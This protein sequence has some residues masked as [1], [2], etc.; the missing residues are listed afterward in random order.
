MRIVSECDSG[1][2]EV[3]ETDGAFGSK[4]NGT[5]TLTEFPA[6]S[7][8]STRTEWSPAVIASSASPSAVRKRI[9]V[10]L[11]NVKITLAT[12]EAASCA[13]QRKTSLFV[14]SPGV[15]VAMKTWGGCESTV[16]FAFGPSRDSRPNFLDTATVAN[17]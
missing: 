9:G 14:H 16:V 17:S 3:I 10:R 2:G 1:A 5:V 7:V 15:G 8:T 12:P 6:R 11:S 4:W 13:I